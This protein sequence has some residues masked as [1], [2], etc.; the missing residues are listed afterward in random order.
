MKERKSQNHWQQHLRQL[1]SQDSADFHF[2]NQVKKPRNNKLF[3][4]KNDFF[5][6][7]L[8]TSPLHEDYSDEGQLTIDV[9]QT[10][11]DIIIK[12]AVAGI[13]AEDLDI[14]LNNDMLTIHGERKQEKESAQKE[15]FYQE[16]YWGKFSRTIILPADVKQD[17]I[18]AQLKNG[19]LTITLPKASSTGSK[20]INVQ[21]IE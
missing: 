15:Y 7:P 2:I 4:E 14:C 3:D 17:K 21:E 8:L 13:N 11:N 16:C 1:E 19:I 5:S 18:K 9:Y 6:S 20:R 10:K 12:A